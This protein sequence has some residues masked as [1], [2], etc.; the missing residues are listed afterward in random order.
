MIGFLVFG[1]VVGALARLFKPGRQN[2]SV[3]MTLLLGVVGS[4]IG[5]VVA[6]LLGTGTIMELNVIG[7]TVAII[8]A[9]MLIGAAEGMSAR[10]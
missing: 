3:G 6:N 4:I 8:A 9:V 7:A 1:L 10:T 5:G 2:L